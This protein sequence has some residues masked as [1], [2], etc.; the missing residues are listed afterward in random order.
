MWLLL[1]IHTV[2]VAVTVTVSGTV[3]ATVTVSALPIGVISGRLSCLPDGIGA[4]P[5]TLH[6]RMHPMLHTVTATVTVTVTVRNK[7]RTDLCP[8]LWRDPAGDPLQSCHVIGNAAVHPGVA[9]EP[10]VGT[11]NLGRH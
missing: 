1:W 3:S 10:R 7:P 6:A 8:S 9:Q 2:S 11:N 5:F 4:F